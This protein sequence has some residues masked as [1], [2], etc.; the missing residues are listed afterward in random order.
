MLECVR[1]GQLEV[2]EEAG[3]WWRALLSGDEKWTQ[4]AGMVHCNW[5]SAT[6]AYLQGGRGYIPLKQIQ[7]ASCRDVWGYNPLQLI[8]ELTA[9]L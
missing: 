9:G 1:T 7:E 6:R 2:R 8:Y 5:Y 4:I 3:D